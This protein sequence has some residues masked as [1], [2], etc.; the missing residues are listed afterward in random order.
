MIAAVCPRRS[1]NSR[2]VWASQTRRPLLRSPEASRAPSGL[3]STAVT[4]SV[5]FLL[6]YTSWPSAVA[7]TRRTLLGPPRATSPWS[8]LM[9]AARTASYSLPTSNT[10]LPVFTSQATARPDCPPRPPPAMSRA[11]LRLNRRT[12]I[13]PS[14]NGTTPTRWWSVVRYRRTCLY[15]PTATSGAHGLAAIATTAAGRAVTTAGS[16][17]SPSGIAG[18]PDGLPAASASSLNSNFGFARTATTLPEVSR[19]PPSIQS[20]MT[21]SSASGILGA[22]GGIVGW[23]LWVTSWKSVLE[24]GSPGS[25]TLP[26]PP[27]CIAEPNVSRFRPPFCLSALWQELQRFRKID[28]AC[29]WKVTFALASAA[30]AAGQRSSPPR[31]SPGRN[32]RMFAGPREEEDRSAD[33]AD[34]R[35]SGIRNLKFEISDIQF[36]RDRRPSASSVDGFSDLSD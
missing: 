27:P 33:D 18:G 7:Y 23:S 12:W 32:D 10:R 21:S 15:P 1:K 4:H 31:S 36:R 16:V 24:S 8:G 19:A 13:V 20:L 25:I 29:S 5:C 28:E 35:R 2:P 30:R 26:D 11:P 14:G 3:N 34:G 9:S 6:S 22:F 17:E